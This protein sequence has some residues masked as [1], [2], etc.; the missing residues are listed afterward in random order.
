LRIGGARADIERDSDTRER[1]LR[2]EASG[3]IESAAIGELDKYT[4]EDP[5]M[6][7]AAAL[8]RSEV[9]SA[10]ELI[11]TALSLLMGCRSAILLLARKLDAL[12]AASG[13]NLQAN[14]SVDD[15]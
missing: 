3:P 6:L 5:V 15:E 1:R 11:P 8:G 4:L 7:E 14:P 9:K 10:E 2:M 12:N 13:G